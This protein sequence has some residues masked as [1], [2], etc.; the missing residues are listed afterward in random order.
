MR[1][2]LTLKDYTKEEILEILELAHKIKKRNK[3]TKYLKSICQK[4][5]LV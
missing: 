5:R 3:K 1:H 4:V 2:F